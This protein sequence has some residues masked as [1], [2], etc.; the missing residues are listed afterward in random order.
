MQVTSGHRAF[1]A[2]GKASAKALSK[3]CVCGVF[4]QDQR[5]LTGLEW[6]RGRVA[7]DIREV[8]ESRVDQWKCLEF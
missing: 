6:R 3:E 2:E 1:Q 4:Q 5:A 7:D 8:A